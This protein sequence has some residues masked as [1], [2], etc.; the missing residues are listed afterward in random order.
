VPNIH[1]HDITEYSVQEFAS[2]IEIPLYGNQTLSNQCFTYDSME[3][4]VQS[5]E[6]NFV[7]NY[8]TIFFDYLKLKVRIK[9][10]TIEMFL[11]STLI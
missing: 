7:R 6:T 11:F 4:I 10:Q 5:I 3:I 8:S 9:C 2:Y 1:T